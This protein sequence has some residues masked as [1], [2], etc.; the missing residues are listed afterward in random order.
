MR[1]IKFRAWDKLTKKMERVRSINFDEKRLFHGTWVNG[2]YYDS[3]FVSEPMQY[4]GLK[5]KN[6]V[7][8]YEGDIV[9]CNTTNTIFTVKFGEIDFN[10][11]SVFTD[12]TIEVTANGFYYQD[13]QDASIMHMRTHVKPDIE[14]EVIGNV[15]ENPELVQ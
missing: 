12:E 10:K 15:Y 1:E 3:E 5:D 13:I 8:I 2:F 6:D 11:V 9:R 4:T 14:W 7:D